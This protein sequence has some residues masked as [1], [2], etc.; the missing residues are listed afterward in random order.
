VLAAPLLGSA[1]GATFPRGGRAV[2]GV[3]RSRLLAPAGARVVDYENAGYRLRW[4]GDEVHVEVDA[5]PLASSSRFPGPSAE[6]PP[7]AARDPIS[8]LARSLTTGAETHYEAVSRVL[9]WVARHVAY[10]ADRR[11]P[12][13]ASAVLERRSGYCTGV[14]RLTVALLEAVGIRAREVAGYVVDAGS[15]TSVSGYHRWIEAYLPDRGW[16]FSDPLTSH[17]YVPATYL[18]LDSDEL[19]PDRGMEGL[20]I[21]R[22]DDLSAVDLYP[23]GAPGVTARRN[24]ERQLAATLHVRVEELGGGLAELTGRSR[25]RTHTLIDGE[26]TFLGLEPGR[27]RL[28]LMVPALGMVE[29]WVELPGRMRKSLSLPAPTRIGRGP[30]IDS[31]RSRDD[32]R[33]PISGGSSP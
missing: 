4:I 24:F 18:R 8:R 12:Q 31:P 33:H 1:A 28:R 15:G 11:Q 29:R 21:E 16:V 13:D 23:A 19:F 7:A 32:S 5:S 22:D 3:D 20:L 25:R 14:A 2:E 10:D 6:V 9:G 17:H 30:G 27:Y 26:T